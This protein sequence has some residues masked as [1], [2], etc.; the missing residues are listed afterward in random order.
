MLHCRIEHCYLVDVE[1]D[2][3]PGRQIDG[4][5]SLEQAS[6]SF[7]ALLGVRTVAID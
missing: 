3:V 4:V 5:D 6:D 7:V 1:L 2:L